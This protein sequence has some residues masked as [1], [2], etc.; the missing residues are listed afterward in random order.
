[1]SITI[2]QTG[3]DGLVVV[4]QRAFSD[5]R[6]FFQEVYRVDTFR[7]TGVDIQ[8]Q[9][10]NMSGS[11]RN[12]LRGL[13]FQWNPQM[14]KLMRVLR[15]RAFLVAVDIRKNSPTCGKWFGRVFDAEDRCQ[16]FGTSGFARGFYVVSDYAEI[17]YMCTA[18]YNPAAESAIRWND[19]EIGIDWPLEGEPILSDKDRDAQTLSRWLARPEA[20]N[21]TR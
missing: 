16:L 7:A 8:V 12:V 1:M 11:V 2:E 20:E 4:R 18:T 14:A 15:G 21:F 6:G 3:L 19:P 5:A 13:H 10:V 9:Q 17:E